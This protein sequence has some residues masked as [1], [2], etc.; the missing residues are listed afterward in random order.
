[1]GQPTIRLEWTRRHNLRNYAPS[2]E[3]A[4]QLCTCIYRLNCMT[5]GTRRRVSQATHTYVCIH[6]LRGGWNAL[7]GLNWSRLTGKGNET[8]S[9][10]LRGWW[11]CLVSRQLGFVIS[12]KFKLLPRCTVHD[13][14]SN[15][16]AVC[17]AIQTSRIT[18]FFFY[19]CTSSG[20]G[21]F[22]PQDPVG[23]WLLCN[24]R[25][26][27]RFLWFSISLSCHLI[28]PMFNVRRTPTIRFMTQF[29]YLWHELL[30]FKETDSRFLFFKRPSGG[31]Q[32]VQSL[33]DIMIME[34]YNVVTMWMSESI[35]MASKGRNI[36]R[37]KE[38]SSCYIKL[39]KLL[40]LWL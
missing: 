10:Y 16:L 13:V 28:G 38:N 5:T 17:T 27:C 3:L 24:Q 11:M 22:S 19:H 9:L 12:P 30:F 36:F 25:A 35:K 40:S 18:R 2:Y 20:Y 14:A 21:S 8:R 6:V 29:E 7:F 15:S 32:K 4:A 33:A 39:V 37:Q 31:V 26:P 23:S 1:M 34:K